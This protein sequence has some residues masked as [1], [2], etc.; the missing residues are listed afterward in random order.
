MLHT[1]LNYTYTYFSQEVCE[2][3]SVAGARRLLLGLGRR[4]PGSQG[5]RQAGSQPARQAASQAARQPGTQARRHAGRQA[6]SASAAGETR[7]ADGGRIL[8]ARRPGRH[9]HPDVGPRLRARSPVRGPAR[10]SLVTTLSIRERGPGPW[11]F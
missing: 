9:E 7:G 1:Y 3:C 10:P 4:K 11:G 5:D 6:G 2:S 8:R